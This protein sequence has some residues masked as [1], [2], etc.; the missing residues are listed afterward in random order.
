MCNRLWPCVS[1]VLALVVATQV[2]TGAAAQEA[3][4][5]ATPMAM[6]DATP[7]ATPAAA[8]LQVLFVQS[9]TAGRLEPGAEASTC[10][11]AS[12]PIT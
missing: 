4:P 2:S 1:V 9:F 7:G 11:W 6:T 3:T 12:L 8:P 5:V 10:R